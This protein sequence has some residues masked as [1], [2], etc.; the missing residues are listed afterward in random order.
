LRGAGSDKQE[1]LSFCFATMYDALSETAQDVAKLIPYLG[2]EWKPMTISIALDVPVETVRVTIFELSD[3]GIIY[4]IHP[5]RADDY[6]VLPLTKEFLWNKWH[7]SHLQKAVDRRFSETFSSGASQGFLLDWPL[8]R[9]IEFLTNL[10]REKSVAD[11]HETALKLVRL[12]VTWLAEIEAGPLETQ[13]RF[14]E[15]YSLYNTTNRTAGLAHMRQAIH[16]HRAHSALRP[17]DIVAFADALYA[18]GGTSSEREASET[19]L[20][21]MQEGAK[22]GASLLDRF[23]DCNLKRGDSKLIAEV[24]SKLLDGNQICSL[25]DKIAGLL[26]SPQV[27]FTYLREWS[28]ALNALA[29]SEVVREEKKRAYLTEFSEIRELAK[30]G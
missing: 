1:L 29:S 28:T 26:R 4:R 8:Q 7:E 3:K 14:I 24:A 5:D 18:H 10:S 19:V 25:F 21:G 6:G 2:N 30:N 9:R 13:L 17:E 23:I 20:A 15:G 27:K 12:A 16:A 22:I 11:D